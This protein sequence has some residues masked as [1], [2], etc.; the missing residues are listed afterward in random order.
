MKRTHLPLLTRMI[1]IIVLCFFWTIY[2]VGMFYV[3]LS[4]AHL[5]K[6]L[7]IALGSELILLL[8]GTITWIRRH[9]FLHKTLKPRKGIPANPWDYAH[10]SLGYTVT[11][12]VQNP[13]GQKVL[14][15]DCDKQARMKSYQSLKK[16]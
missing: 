3:S 1:H 6:G 5:Y 11:F 15:V 16:G 8:I 2:G 13:K 4:P 12:D 9:L 14:I 7:I 10:D